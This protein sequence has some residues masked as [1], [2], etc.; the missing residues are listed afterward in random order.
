MPEPSTITRARLEQIRLSDGDR[1]SEI[2]DATRTVEVQFNPESLKVTYANTVAGDDQAG[3]AA[4]QHV[5]KSS[6]KLAVDLWFDA[7]VR[8][9]LSDVREETKKVNH[10]LVPVPLPEGGVAPPPVRFIWG[11]FLF[12]GVMQ[13]MDETLEFFSSAGRPL[14]AKVAISMVSQDIQFRIAAAQETGTPGAR[15]QTPATAGEGLQQ[16]LGR[17]GDPEGWQEIAAANGIENPRFLAPGTFVDTSP[18]SA[19]G[20]LPTSTRG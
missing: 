3:G 4:I 13:S 14:R 12:E 9:D 17:R 18:P 16:L 5:S 20:P 2:T 8:P 10:F 15:P 1:P 7:S 6:T 19:A 11:T